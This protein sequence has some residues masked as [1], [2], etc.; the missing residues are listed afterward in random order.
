MID[1]I[2]EWNI[3]S[4][5]LNLSISPDENGCIINLDQIPQLVLALMNL[6]LISTDY[7]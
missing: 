3:I 1:N 5:P 4:L 6:I 7:Y 2:F